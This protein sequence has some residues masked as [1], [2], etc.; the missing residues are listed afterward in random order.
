[1]A[2]GHSA[3]AVLANA[4][5]AAG[6][7]PVAPDAGVIVLKDPT[8]VAGCRLVVVVG[9]VHGVELVDWILCLR[10]VE[11]PRLALLAVFCYRQ[12]AAVH[13]PPVVVAVPARRRCNEQQHH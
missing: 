11:G 1:M 10:L 13:R 7:V 12:V 2:L 8:V 9:R 5:P 3:V 6:L 4:Q